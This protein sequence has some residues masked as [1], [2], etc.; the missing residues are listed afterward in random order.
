[1]SCSLP[2]LSYPMSYSAMV[3]LV[4]DGSPAVRA[5]L[6]LVSLTHANFNIKTRSQPKIKGKIFLN[7][8]QNCRLTL[9][10]NSLKTEP[11]AVPE[12][13]HF[14]LCQDIDH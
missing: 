6:Q 8:K 13:W 5:L 4:R 12:L 11:T 9:H 14:L 7:S 1:M 2:G 3:R 10:D